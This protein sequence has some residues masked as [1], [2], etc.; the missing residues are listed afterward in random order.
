MITTVSPVFPVN[1]PSGFFIGQQ[2]TVV[3]A[4]R[5]KS[6]KAA[7][8]NISALGPL[9]FVADHRVTRVASG[10]AYADEGVAWVRGWID[11]TDALV[12][13]RMLVGSAEQ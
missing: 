8:A 4:M 12:A 13:T 1:P 3:Y 9:T 5:G 2:V 6:F 7:H 10:H 11:D